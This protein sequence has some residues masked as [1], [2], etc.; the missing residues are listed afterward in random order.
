[1]SP[2]FKDA[3]SI[4]HTSLF[5]LRKNYSL[6]IQLLKILLKLLGLNQILFYN[7][8]VLSCGGINTPNPAQVARIIQS[9]PILQSS[10]LSCGVTT[11]NP[12]QL[13]RIQ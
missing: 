2:T 12:A 5:L 13:A 4:T 8:A 1:M 6:V 11:T 7:Q 3:N 9:N 10:P